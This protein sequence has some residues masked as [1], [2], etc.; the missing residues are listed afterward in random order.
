[1][2]G[3]WRS[4]GL[5]LRSILV[6]VGVALAVFAFGPILFGQHSYK[7]LSGSMSPQIETGDLV[8]ARSI[9]PVSARVG[10]IVTFVDPEDSSRLINHRIVQIR[11]EMRQISFVTRGDANTTTEHWSVARSGTIGLVEY[12]IPKLGYGLFWI[13]G[14]A[15]RLGLMVV[16]A[17]LLVLLLVRSIRRT[18][19]EPA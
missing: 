16:P 5:L 9:S 4:I 2:R 7:V 14:R 12:R 18:Q 19:P 15:G 8:V 1:M 11:P 13:S 6:G 3:V 17:L 10:Q